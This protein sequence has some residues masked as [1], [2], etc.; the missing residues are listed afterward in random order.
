M[1]I[2]VK[3]IKEMITIDSLHKMTVGYIKHNKYGTCLILFFLFLFFFFIEISPSPFL[4]R[5]IVLF[6]SDFFQI[7][8]PI[9]I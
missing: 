8:Q 1:L 6:K 7:S 9:L 4:T 5:R 2:V 3:I